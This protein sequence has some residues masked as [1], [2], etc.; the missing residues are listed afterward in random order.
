MYQTLWSISLA[1]RSS[2][3]RSSCSVT[4]FAALL[5][6]RSSFGAILAFSPSGAFCSTHTYDGRY[7]HHHI[8][9][10]DTETAGPA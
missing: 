3:G 1:M 6:S 8:M 10:T 7:Q 4:E 5:D 9:P 2:R